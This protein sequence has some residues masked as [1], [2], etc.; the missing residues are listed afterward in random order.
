MRVKAITTALLVTGLLML[1][2]WPKF[3]GPTPATDAPR[4]AKRQYL[5][6]AAFYVSGILVCIFGAA[7]GA[8]FV[9]R[10]MRNEYREQ[11]KE[12]L[13]E[14]LEGTLK[15]HGKSDS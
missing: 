5:R 7:V 14:L 8:V 9:A 12:N 1:V 11:A 10:Q 2:L 6:Y 3:V 13:N 15:D 4:A